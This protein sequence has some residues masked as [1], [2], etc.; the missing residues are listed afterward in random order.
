MSE[1]RDSYE[2]DDDLC[3]CKKFERL[4]KRAQDIQVLQLAV[5]MHQGA[6]EADA[7]SKTDLQKS[8]IDAYRWLND[9]LDAQEEC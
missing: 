9:L 4:E 5:D 2:D 8:I 6:I 7:L 1:Y 3:D